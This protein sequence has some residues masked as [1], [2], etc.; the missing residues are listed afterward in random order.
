MKKHVMFDFD[1]VV[2]PSFE[3]C[4]EVRRSYEP[5]LS[6]QAYR[7][8]FMGN[9]FDAVEHKDFDAAAFFAQYQK[10]MME[11]QPV[12]YIDEAIQTLSKAYH[13]TVVS[14]SLS[15][16]IDDYLQRYSLRDF[17]SEILGSD[18]D[19]SK[20][21]K[22]ESLLKTHD[23]PTHSAVLITDTVGDIKE[24]GRV[25]VRSI[26]VSWGFHD[27]ETLAAEA[28]AGLVDRPDRLAQIVSQTLG[29]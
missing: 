28:P 9:V 15:S 3:T 22:I 20:E 24:A 21:R 7:Q 17:F 14:S 4:Y 8:E 25:G 23:T 27:K 5:D 11:I 29:T 16:L 12:Q 19:T 1:G 26:A 6:K 13:L 10:R 18:V 2:L